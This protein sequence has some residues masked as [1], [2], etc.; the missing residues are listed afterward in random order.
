MYQFEVINP[1][2]DTAFWDIPLLQH[3]K[4]QGLK[5][6]FKMNMPISYNFLA[7]TLSSKLSDF[8]TRTMRTTKLYTSRQGKLYTSTDLLSRVLF[9]AYLASNLF[10]C[11]AA[12]IFLSLYLSLFLFFCL[13][14]S[15]TFFFPSLSVSLFLLYFYFLPAHTPFLFIS[16]Q[17]P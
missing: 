17:K 2:L 8:F 4:E 12:S 11:I 16:R 1:R 6:T 5:K 13:T 15:F 14:L 7:Y 3:R 9:Y 10:T